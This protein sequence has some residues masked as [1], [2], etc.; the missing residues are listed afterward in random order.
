[1]H[2][3]RALLVLDRVGLD[4][5]LAHVALLAW[6]SEEVRGAARVPVAAVAVGQR[7]RSL[8]CAAMYSACRIASVTMVSVGFSAPP[9]VN[10]LPSLMNRLRMSCVWPYLLHHAVG[11]PGAHAAVPRLCVEG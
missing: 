7:A 1:M 5:I 6:G 10:W 11:G 4:E 8:I 3:A 9:L 2:G